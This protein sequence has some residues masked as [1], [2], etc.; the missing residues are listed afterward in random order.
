V[1]PATGEV[2]SGDAMIV[3]IC[4]TAFRVNFGSAIAAGIADWKPLSTQT[5]ISF[6]LL[7]KLPVGG[8]NLKVL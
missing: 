4:S 6:L 1:T 7:S 5:S 3:F 2:E 8:S